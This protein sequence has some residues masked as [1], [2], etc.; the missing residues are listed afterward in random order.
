MFAILIDLA[1]LLTYFG[2]LALILVALVLGFWPVF[3]SPLIAFLQDIRD[4]RACRQKRRNARK[5]TER[6]R[7]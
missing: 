6:R 5:A 2:A 1:P 3:E 7:P 4:W